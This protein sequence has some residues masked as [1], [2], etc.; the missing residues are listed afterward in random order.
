MERPIPPSSGTR[1]IAPIMETQTNRP[2]DLKRAFSEDGAH[3]TYIGGQA[4]IEGIMMR[5]RTHWSVALR[6]SDGSIHTEE[7]ALSA[8][9]NRPAWLSWPLIRGCVALV[10][11]LALGFKALEISAQHALSDEAKTDRRTAEP[12]DEV[13]IARHPDESKQVEFGRGDMVL[14]ALLGLV[15]GLA[16]FVFVP[17]VLANLV[18][19]SYD[20]NTFAWN[21]VD[22]VAR[23]AVF[24]FYVWLI[25]RMKDI[26]VMFAYHGAEHKTIHCYEHGCD[27]TVANARSFPRL[28]VRCGT[29][30]LIMVMI[31][32]ILVYTIVPL[33]ALIS[34]WGVTDDV[35][36]FALVIVARIVLLPLIAGLSYEISVK[37][38]G[39]HPENPLVKVLLWPSMQ[40]QYLTTAE[41]DDA[42]LECAIAAMNLIVEREST[43]D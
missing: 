7:H 1:R 35:A 43:A 36:Q 17:A 31:I 39:S 29:A 16:L 3:K 18:V 37:W 34:A 41:P 38:A 2:S 5:G 42:Q 25:A 4:L 10:D 32:A 27:L 40:M 23:V 6:S 15:L 28:H 9:G 19:G 30:F 14:S 8:K 12:D 11:S 21:C 24:V 13:D 22:G 33:D 20:T 26:R